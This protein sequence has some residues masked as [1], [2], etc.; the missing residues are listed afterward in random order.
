MHHAR[1]SIVALALL[2]ATSAPASAQARRVTAVIEVLSRDRTPVIPCGQLGPQPREVVARVLAVEEGSFAPG[3]VRLRWALCDF[4]RV[5][6]GSRFR[7]RFQTTA[8]VAPTPS[9]VYAVTWSEALAA[10][11]RP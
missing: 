3:T 5:E 4:S 6:P 9:S 10:E 7:V 2:F 1:R 11:R 8:G